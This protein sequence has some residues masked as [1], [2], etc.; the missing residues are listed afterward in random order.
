MKRRVQIVSFLTH[1][2][3]GAQ[4]AVND[5]FSFV[6]FLKVVKTLYESSTFTQLGKTVGSVLKDGKEEDDDILDGDSY[7]LRELD[8]ESE[9]ARQ[10]SVFEAIAKACVIATKPSRDEVDS[11]SSVVKKRPKKA[12]N[13][14]LLE[15]V[16]NTCSVFTHPEGDD[17]ADERSLTLHNST[18]DNYSEYDNTATGE[19]S[20][21]T[22]SEEEDYE[23][24]KRRTRSK[25]R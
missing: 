25:R 3:L 19:S 18:E 14:S 21:E 6:R 15:Q 24:R 12:T 11:K 7:N 13:D 22:Y 20:F 4:L 5:D 9:R 2:I 10:E 8:D 16:L 17:L 1:S 23:E